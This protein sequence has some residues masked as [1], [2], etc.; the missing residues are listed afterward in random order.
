M[1]RQDGHL[2]Y[3]KPQIFNKLKVSSTGEVWTG[4]CG[5]CLGGSLT[6]WM[7]ISTR[8]AKGDQTFPTKFVSIK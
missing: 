6:E 5:Y 8:V 1:H 3:T 2:Q 4:Q 7:L